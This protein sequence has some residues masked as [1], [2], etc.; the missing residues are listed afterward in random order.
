M[1]RIFRK[2]FQRADKT[3]EIMLY[4][5]AQH[6]PMPCFIMRI[7]TKGAKINQGKQKDRAGQFKSPRLWSSPEH[8][9]G[10]EIDSMDKIASIDCQT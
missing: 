5:A 2:L 4:G 3:V 8:N 10:K 7:G 9:R 6:I 1:P